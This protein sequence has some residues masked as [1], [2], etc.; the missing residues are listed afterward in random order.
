[1]MFYTYNLAKMEGAVAL[2][3]SAMLAVMEQAG[4]EVEGVIRKAVYAKGRFMDYKL[5][6][7]FRKES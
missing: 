7:C 5:F 2:D 6:A 4:C 1:M 3:N